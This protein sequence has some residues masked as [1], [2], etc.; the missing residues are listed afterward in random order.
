M[1]DCCPLVGGARGAA[2]D[3]ISPLLRAA[4]SLLHAVLPGVLAPPANLTRAPTAA[5][6]VLELLSSELDSETPAGVLD[7]A[8]TVLATLDTTLRFL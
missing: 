7:H 8:T 3:M 6:V 4:G 2:A 5:E 1:C